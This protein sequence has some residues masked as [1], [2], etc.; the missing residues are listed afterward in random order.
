MK[1]KH[2]TP[3]APLIR[4]ETATPSPDAPQEIPLGDKGKVA[5]A[6]FAIGRDG[7]GLKFL[8]YDKCLT[9]LARENRHNPTPAETLLWQKVLRGKQFEHYKFLRQKPIG[10][11]IVYFYCAEFRLVIEIDGDSH[12]EQLDY[13]AQRT[14]FLNGLGLQVIRNFN[15]DVLHELPVLYD[16]LLTHLPSPNHEQ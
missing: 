6:T 13:D 4:G 8:P 12:A 7:E 9:A 5:P 1:A 16:N 10:D 3:P 15:R 2:P 11:Y 14:L